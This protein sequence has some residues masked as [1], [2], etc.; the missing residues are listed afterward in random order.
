MNKR[1]HSHK[2]IVKFTKTEIQR[3]EDLY[4]D[5]YNKNTKILWQR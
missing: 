4:W 2:T 5:R 3:I 1:K